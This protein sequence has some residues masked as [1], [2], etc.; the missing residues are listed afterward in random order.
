MRTHLKGSNDRSVC[1]RLSGKYI[2]CMASIMLQNIRDF[3]KDEV[4]YQKKKK[5][6]TTNLSDFKGK[7]CGVQRE[8]DD[9]SEVYKIPKRFERIDDTR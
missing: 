8:R 5:R 7:V 4:F 3:F 6:P 2:K 9:L 1:Q